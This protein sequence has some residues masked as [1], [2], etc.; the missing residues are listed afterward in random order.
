MDSKQRSLLVRA[1]FVLGEQTNAE[2]AVYRRWRRVFV[3]ALP[4]LMGCADRCESAERI[5]LHSEE[6]FGSFTG[7][8][9]IPILR[10]PDR[11][12]LRKLKRRLRDR[13]ETSLA[14]IHARVIKLG[15]RRC[16]AKQAVDKGF[17]FSNADSVANAEQK[18]LDFGFDS[19]PCDGPLPVAETSPL[20]LP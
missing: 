13:L 3:N 15:V 6:Q 4:K 5:S 19:V 10:R 2:R 20:A 18:T 12:Q 14:P 7:W 16:S 9:R 1:D 17:K 11:K 8:V